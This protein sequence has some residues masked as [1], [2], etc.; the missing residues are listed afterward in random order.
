MTVVGECFLAGGR[1]SE[2]PGECAPQAGERGQPLMP[3]IPLSWQASDS[4]SQSINAVRILACPS[5]QV[6]RTR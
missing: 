1:Y 3:R 2:L 5:Q 6:T 4:G